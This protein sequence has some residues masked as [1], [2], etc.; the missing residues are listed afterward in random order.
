MIYSHFVK[1]LFKILNSLSWSFSEYRIKEL[2]KRMKFCGENVD[3]HP[4]TVI[5]SAPC[6]SIGNDVCIHAFTHIFAGGSLTIGNGAMISS[7][8]S[9]T[10]VTHEVH[11]ATR[12]T[13]IY[14]PIVIGE[15]VWIGT[16]AV[17]L[18]GVTIGDYA[19]IGAGAVVTKDVP[20]KQVFVG[21]PATFLKHVCI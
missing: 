14:K 7:N 16:G 10:T 2:K 1:L 18:P 4:Q 21:N 20:A 11:A 5:W 3:I 8:C 13:G 17:I 6:L 9:I 15:N 19:I 12:T